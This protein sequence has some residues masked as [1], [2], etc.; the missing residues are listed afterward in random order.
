MFNESEVKCNQICFANQTWTD[1]EFPTDQSSLVPAS[2]TA[3]LFAGA[4]WKRI[5]D[6]VPQARL[7]G[8]KIDEK[9]FVQG[10]IADGYL[11]AALCALAES[12]VMIKRL[13]YLDSFSKAG[14]LL[15]Y[16]RFDGAQTPILV[17]DQIPCIDKELLFAKCTRN[18]WVCI[19]EKAWA[20]LHGS[21]AAIA[22]GMP[23]FVFGQLAGLP[24]QVIEHKKITNRL[25][26]WSNLIKW[27]L[28]HCPIIA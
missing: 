27:K 9:N 28:H 7:F 23:S 15:V 5:S 20:K 2:E 22:R 11:L 13:F 1:P 26:F 25:E 21:Y 14:C 3:G 18:I 24:T 19:I 16:F 12:E 8:A 4:C 10:E 6:V 17:D